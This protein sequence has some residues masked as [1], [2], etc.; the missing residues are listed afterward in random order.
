MRPTNSGEQELRQFL[1][2]AFG[3]IFLSLKLSHGFPYDFVGT[4]VA[5]ILDFFRNESFE[6]FA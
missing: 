5:A 1:A 6:F 4:G 2:V 3:G